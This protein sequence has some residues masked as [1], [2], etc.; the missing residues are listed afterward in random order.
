MEAYIGSYLLENL[1]KNSRVW[2]TGSYWQ[3][4]SLGEGGREKEEKE[5]G[6]EERNVG[7]GLTT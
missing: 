4:M 5:G 2:N 3:A 1:E 6:K 7:K